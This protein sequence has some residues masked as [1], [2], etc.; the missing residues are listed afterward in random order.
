MSVLARVRVV[1]VAFVLAAS[2]AVALS[3]FGGGFA[4]C[5]TEPNCPGG[6]SAEMWN[7]SWCQVGPDGCSLEGENCD[8]WDCECTD[9]GWQCE[10]I[11]A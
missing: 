8:S 2:M 4:S 10:F 7:C 1:F 9:P 11:V 5:F 3:A 6:C